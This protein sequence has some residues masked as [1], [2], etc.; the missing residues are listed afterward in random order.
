[1]HNIP[2]LIL[3]GGKGSRVKSLYPDKPK[4]LIEFNGKPFLELLLSMLEAHGFKEVILCTGFGKNQVSSWIN[5][6][7]KGNLCIIFSN[8]DKPLG[9]A[10]AIKNAEKYINN[11]KFFVINGDTISN[12][13]FESLFNFFTEM[14][15][16]VV[17]A[18]AKTENQTDYGCIT[19]DEK[20]R[21]I[22]FNE[23]TGKYSNNLKIYVNS[24]YYLF[25][26]K[27]LNFISHKN[28][29][30]LEYQLLPSL[31]KNI[32]NNVYGYYSEKI[33]F[34][35]YGSPDRLSKAKDMLNKYLIFI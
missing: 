2:V 29:V 5:N 19:I 11:N 25:N 1:M 17:I 15:A 18:L 3:C 20:N 12:I 7:Y 35:D 16:N 32:G 21:I 33:E 6:Y 30:S 31:V 22:E 4:I 14:N 10:G 9:T 28:N 34:F 24:G 26:N 27:V 13:S 23:K 8:E